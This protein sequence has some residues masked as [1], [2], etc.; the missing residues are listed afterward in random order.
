MPHACKLQKWRDVYPWDWKMHNSNLIC[1]EAAAR[2][3]I[4][5]CMFMNRNH[6]RDWG[7]YRHGPVTHNFF[8]VYPVHSAA[9]KSSCSEIFSTVPRHFI[10]GHLEQCLISVF[11]WMLITW[12]LDL[13]MSRSG[14]ADTWGASFTSSAT[15]SLFRSTS[16][17]VPL[18]RWA[19]SI[20]VSNTSLSANTNVQQLLRGRSAVCG[21]VWQGR[22]CFWPVW[23]P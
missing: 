1:T 2:W 9:L 23:E 6:Y 8:I 15:A 19:T 22:K 10:C 12:S 13:S 4:A 16:Q 21:C 18:I 5:H 7:A 17:P 11:N 3:R 20:H 14:H